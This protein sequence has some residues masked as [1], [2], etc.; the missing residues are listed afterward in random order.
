[1][2]STSL[3]KDILDLGF[4]DDLEDIDFDVDFTNAVESLAHAVE[5]LYCDKCTNT[6]KTHSGLQRHIAKKHV[7]KQDINYN[8]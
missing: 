5:L 2:A 3:Y 1:M 4:L 7:V 6:Y 8:Y